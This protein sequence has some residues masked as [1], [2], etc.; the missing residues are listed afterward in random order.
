MELEQKKF[1]YVVTCEH[2]ETGS[3][4]DGVFD[5]EELARDY[6]YEDIKTEGL[7]PADFED[8]LDLNYNRFCLISNQNNVKDNVGI[9]YYIYCME[10]DFAH[11]WRDR[12]FHVTRRTPEV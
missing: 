5:S 8:S 1:V 11:G 6:I 4:C 2:P 12:Q 3:S 9:Y 10:R 7:N